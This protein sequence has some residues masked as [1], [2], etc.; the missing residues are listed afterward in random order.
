MIEQ[1]QVIRVCAVFIFYADFLFSD[2]SK[3]KNSSYAIYFLDNKHFSGV[4]PLSE[5]PSLMRAVGFY[6]SEEEVTNMINE[7]RAEHIH[8][9]VQ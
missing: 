9:T 4:I 5:I 3:I 1:P 2:L 7:V 6:P 8:S